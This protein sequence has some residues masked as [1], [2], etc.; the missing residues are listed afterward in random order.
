MPSIVIPLTVLQLSS[1]YP[2]SLTAVLTL[3]TAVAKSQPTFSH[4]TPVRS[5]GLGG[6]YRYCLEFLIFVYLCA[7]A[8][9]GAPSD[10]NTP[11][12]TP[13]PTQPQYSWFVIAALG[14][15]VSIT[16][17]FQASISLVT[18]PPAAPAGPRTA[19]GWPPIA[20]ALHPAGHCSH[21][22][23][24]SPELPAAP[25]KVREVCP[26]ADQA[27]TSQPEGKT[28]LKGLSRRC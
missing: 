16:S 3:P 4:S 6:W 14:I 28:V 24:A 27:V 9:S 5:P 13:S 12:R 23:R 17:R 26:P 19:R 8:K 18:H 20:S 11:R 21:H 15:W 2:A 10:A 7:R 22:P 1:A 25:G